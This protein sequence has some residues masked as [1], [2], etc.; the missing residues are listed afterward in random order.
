MEVRLQKF[1]AECG[2]CSRRAAEDMI[3]AGRVTVNGV[4]AELGKKVG[5]GDVVLV[6]GKIV[7]RSAKDFTYIMLHKPRGYIT[8]MADEEGRKCVADL[9]EGVEAR[10]VPIGRLDRNSEGLLLLS[11]D[12]DLVYKLTHPSHDVAKKYIV[13]MEGLAGGDALDKLASLKEIDGSRLKPFQVEVLK[14]TPERSLLGFTLFEGK[15]RQIRRMCE[16]AGINVMRLKR[17]SVGDLRL[18]EVKSGHFRHLTKEEVA[19]LKKLVK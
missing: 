15:N 19:K 17:V 16:A 4:K 11:D 18:A 14:K 7:R 3:T 5:D 13:T 6:D 12:G 8:T 2:I 10:V 9:L 1:M